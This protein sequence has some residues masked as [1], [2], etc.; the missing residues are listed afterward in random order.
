MYKPYI[1]KY[2]KHIY[3]ISSGIVIYNK[4]EA[5]RIAMKLLNN[6]LWVKVKKK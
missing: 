6:G 4:H 2:K 3:Q 1:I 5:D